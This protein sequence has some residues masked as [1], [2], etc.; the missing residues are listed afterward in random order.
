MA[1]TKVLR[2]LGS[3]VCG[4]ICCRRCPSDQMGKAPS[5][6]LTAT[7]CGQEVA[8]HSCCLAWGEWDT[9][10]AS[11]LWRPPASVDISLLVLGGGEEAAGGP[12]CRSPTFPD[13]WC[14]CRCILLSFTMCF[15]FR[16]ASRWGFS[17]LFSLVK[18]KKCSMIRYMWTIP[19]SG[20]QT[21][22]PPCGT[23]QSF[24]MVIKHR[25]CLAST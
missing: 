10:A 11:G 1:R 25:L 16:F 20:R 9:E 24:K 5:S 7:G 17:K 21:R 2:T 19:G 8:P 18:T 12:S 4:V 3:F 14:L 23:S 15:P 13:L 22:F 6:R